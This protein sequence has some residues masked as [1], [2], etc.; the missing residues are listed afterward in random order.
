[1]GSRIKACLFAVAAL[2]A[3]TSVSGGNPKLIG[4]TGTANAQEPTEADTKLQWSIAAPGR[5]EP[6]AGQVKI[7]ATTIGRVLDI[8]VE[9]GQRVKAGHLLVRL[10]DAEA[11]ARVLSTE[12]E[13]ELR[14]RARNN[15]GTTRRARRRRNASDALADAEEELFAARRELDRIA[16]DGNQPSADELSLSEAMAKVDKARER[17]RDNREKL[18]KIRS[19][20]KTPLLTQTESA[21][22]L[23][24]ANRTLAYEAFE[25]T[26][27]RAPSHG[28]V[29]KI[30]VRE[31]EVVAPTAMQP[32]ILFGDVSS[33]RVRT[34]VDERDISNVNTGQ[35]VTI[36]SDAFEGR[37]FT[38]EVSEI[39]P[40]L[41]PGLIGKRGPE[42]PLNANVL[43]VMVDIKGSSP[44]IPGMQVDVL[45][46][47]NPASEPPEV[48]AKAARGGSG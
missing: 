5:V 3:M 21:L 33:L 18:R 7:G 45:F 27:I 26:R 39:S 24:R 19:D 28:T 31:G 6:K 32:V 25:K 12:A 40:A 46:N 36:R 37:D 2:A 34:E 9:A 35:I 16:L 48:S 4:L 14:Q 22:A 23:A 30:N 42:R 43:E 44:L 20:N 1:V 38:G 29:L 47:A 11:M 8:S 15:R 10:E 13:V 17:V 41:G